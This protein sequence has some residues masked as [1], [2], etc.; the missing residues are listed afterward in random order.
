ML[1][2]VFLQS[3]ISILAIRS[4]IY[5]ENYDQGRTTYSL[6][7]KLLYFI[8]SGQSLSLHIY[9]NSLPTSAVLN[10]LNPDQA[11]QNVWPDQ[12]QYCLTL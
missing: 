6:C 11:R 8:N 5:L 12:D 9:I 4:L 3:K 2:C 7:V 1:K 10:S